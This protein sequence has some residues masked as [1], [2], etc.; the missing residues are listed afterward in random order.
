M[1]GAMP[2]TLRRKSRSSE[3]LVRHLTLVLALGASQADA[4]TGTVRD[5]IT[6]E[7]LAGASVEIVDSDW[8]TIASNDGAFV[9]LGQTPP[10]RLR[11]SR[12]GYTPFVIQVDSG[13]VESG[14]IDVALAPAPLQMAEMII[15]GRDPAY[16]IMRRV[17]ERKAEWTQL[18]PSWRVEAYTRQT[19]FA[20]SRILA[21]REAA[22]ELF[23][24]RDEGTRENLTA[25]RASANVPDGL[26]VFPV[27][28]YVFDLYADEVRIVGETF[29]G[30]TA[31]DADNW[32]QFRL[33][34]KEGD[35]FHIAVHP[36]R[37]KPSL[38]GSL[39]VRD[40]DFAL[41]EA[42]LRPNRRLTH[43]HFGTATGFSFVLQQRFARFEPGVWLPTTAGVEI[44]GD[45]GTSVGV[46]DVL[47]GPR[48]GRALLKSTTRYV[49]HEVAAPSVRYAFLGE[50]LFRVGQV[51]PTWLKLL[52]REVPPAT[53]DQQ[54]AFQ[55]LQ[56]TKTVLAQ[57]PQSVLLRLHEHVPAADVVDAI[58]A[59]PLDQGTLVSDE[60]IKNIIAG[61]TNIQVDSLLSDDGPLPVRGKTTS[62]IWVNRVDALHVGLR[63]RGE[64]L[65][66]RRVGLYLKG[67]YNIGA[68]RP[69]Y[70]L[71]LRKAWGK[72]GETYSGLLYR[73][74]TET[75]TASATYSMV[76]NS[77]PYLLNQGDYFDFYRN[78]G[79]RAEWGKILED[80]SYEV[81]LNSERHSSLTNQTDRTVCDYQSKEGQLYDW[82]CGGT[83]VNRP[84][85]AIDEGRLHSLDGRLQM[86]DVDVLG[87]V[88][89]EVE[90]ADDWMGGDFSFARVDLTAD[91][92]WLRRS[93]PVV[94]PVSATYRVQAGA[95]MGETPP[96][97]RRAID[98]NMLG[99]SP[100][101]VLRT[102]GDR[103]YEADDYVAMFGEWRWGDGLLRPMAPVFKPARWAVERLIGPQTRWSLGWAMHTGHARTWLPR[104]D[105]EPR[106]ARTWHHEAGV[107]LSAFDALNLDMTWR[108]DQRDRRVGLSF[109]HSF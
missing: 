25:R 88:D 20:G 65:W 53:P 86:G 80:S 105:V 72:E 40:E 83:A 102:L 58:V 99:V 109:V 70:G 84:N 29:V 108:L 69:T 21:I 49:R 18:L 100:F 60:L 32:Y 55:D 78:E 51:A 36:R 13:H 76:D 10:F 44:E 11:T 7:P 48:P 89:V 9:L 75:R 8:A 2:G 85:P 81:G 67:G 66:G 101:G 28:G 19:L 42:R 30:P 3:R 107:S 5:A 52:D 4:I 77:Y 73:A 41:V 74:Q 35:L 98:A 26:T 96:Q 12:V 14:H 39:I 90:Y 68:G 22:S 92:R 57:Q 16:D 45:P 79:V 82:L 37:D 50:D 63:W 38:L 17:A 43:P 93:Y 24:M 31:Q 54:Q 27:T 47:A 62:E 106:Q 6:G 103:P 64:S 87:S 91:W 61:T 46:T 33:A 71:G 56:Q 34:G 95:A 1:I 59:D 94:L 15:D 23:H 97:R 104:M